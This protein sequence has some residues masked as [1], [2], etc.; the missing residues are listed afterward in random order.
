MGRRKNLKNIPKKPDNSLTGKEAQE[1][2]DAFLDYEVGSRRV[3]NK[4]ST[5]DPSLLRS[6]LDFLGSD[7]HNRPFGESETITKQDLYKAALPVILDKLP[8]MQRAIIKT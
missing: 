2:W 6:N 8:T 1:A 7:W 3:T 4:F 5:V